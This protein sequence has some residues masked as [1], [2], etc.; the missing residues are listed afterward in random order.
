MNLLPV[1]IS[2][3]NLTFPEKFWYLLSPRNTKILDS[4]IIA[5]G[6]SYH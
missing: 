4:I 2:F 3:N 5:A 6:Y 1:S